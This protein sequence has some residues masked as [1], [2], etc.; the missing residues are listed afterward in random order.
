MLSWDEFYHELEEECS[1]YSATYRQGG[2]YFCERAVSNND[3]AAIV[4]AKAALDRLDLAEGLVELE[5]SLNGLTV[6]RLGTIVPFFDD[7]SHAVYGFYDVH[8]DHIQ[9]FALRDI[10]NRIVILFAAFLLSAIYCARVSAARNA[11]MR[12]PLFAYD[13]ELSIDRHRIRSAI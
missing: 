10:F 3:S 9:R 7:I 12:I 11:L 1:N 8:R 13:A 6:R 2:T 5:Q 4:R